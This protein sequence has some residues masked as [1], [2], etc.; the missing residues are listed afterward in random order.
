MAKAAQPPQRNIGRS[1][2]FLVPA[3]YLAYVSLVTRW[4][5]AVL[6]LFALALLYLLLRPFSVSIKSISLLTVV[7]LAICGLLN[8]TQPMLVDS[9][10]IFSLIILIS[11]ALQPLIFLFII[12]ALIGLLEGSRRVYDM[13]VVVVLWTS[14]LA[15]S[16]GSTALLHGSQDQSI[17]IFLLF[18][19]PW[20][21][22][23]FAL[24]VAAFLM[25]IARTKSRRTRTKKSARKSR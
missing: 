24:F 25:I 23:G 13:A 4:E 21:I 7:Y 8:F 3:V 1:L 22:N 18:I 20:I 17:S 5:V 14:T 11:M 9:W 16:L 2:L 12:D 15:V 10:P 19:M 6:A